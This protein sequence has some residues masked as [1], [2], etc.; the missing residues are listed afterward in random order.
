MTL[1]RTKTVAAGYM[2]MMAEQAAAFRTAT[3]SGSASGSGTATVSITPPVHAGTPP[4]VHA[5]STP[6]PLV[7]VGTSTAVHAET[8]PLHLCPPHPT[9]HPTETSRD[10]YIYSWMYRDTFLSPPSG[11]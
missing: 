11:F 6:P 2:Q 7:H 8:P 1:R 5:G 4:P 9:E 3:G 10:Q